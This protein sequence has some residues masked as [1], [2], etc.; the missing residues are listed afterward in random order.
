VYGDEAYGWSAERSFVSGPTAEQ[1]D[2]P[3]TLFAFGDMGK[4]T[5]VHDPHDQ[6]ALVGLAQHALA[7]R[8]GR[9]GGVMS[10]RPTH[11]AMLP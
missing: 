8:V 11:H 2:R 4:T 5:Q 10:G 6:Q 3:L 1:R 9:R 7:C